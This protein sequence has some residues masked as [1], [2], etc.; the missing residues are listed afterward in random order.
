MTAQRNENYL[1][2]KRANERIKSNTKIRDDNAHLVLAM[3]FYLKNAPGITDE[4]GEN[5]RKMMNVAS[6]KMLKAKA[7][8]EDDRKLVAENREASGIPTQYK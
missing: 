4:I 3:D 8:V 6:T 1:I 2:R 5:I 7:A